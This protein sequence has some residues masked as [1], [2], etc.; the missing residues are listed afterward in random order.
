VLSF[1]SPT[2]QGSYVLFFGDPLKV[3]S[4]QALN[5]ITFLLFAIQNQKMA[6]SFSHPPVHTVFLS[7][8][9]GLTWDILI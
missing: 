6:K 1:N 4:S 9:T 5:K 7:A 8:E 3:N 2:P